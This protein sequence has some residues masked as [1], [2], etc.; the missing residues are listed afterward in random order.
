MNWFKIGS[1]NFTCKALYG[2]H[3]QDKALDDGI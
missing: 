2:F 3:E 1:C